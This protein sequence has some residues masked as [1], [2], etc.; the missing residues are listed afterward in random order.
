MHFNSC[1]DEHS[2]RE[3]PTEQGVNVESLN[4]HLITGD[5]AFAIDAGGKIIMWNKASENAFGFPK[6]Y[7]L[8]KQCWKLLAG[9]DIHGNRYCSKFCPLREMNFRHEPV[10]G[11]RTFFNSANGEENPY[12]V[13]FVTLVDQPGQEKLLHICHPV[14]MEQEQFAIPTT[15]H[16]LEA[17]ELGELSRREIEVLSL[18]AKGTRTQ[19]IADALSISI[20]TVR[21]HIQH[22]MQKLRVHKRKDAV[23]VAK[24]NALI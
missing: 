5:P 18:V 7:A 12:D 3:V 24:E 8:G 19:Q 16:K 13:S 14:E 10:H 9:K 11:F 20:R 15:T 23:R 22:A 21:T 17:V 6:T 2:H 4:R 1:M